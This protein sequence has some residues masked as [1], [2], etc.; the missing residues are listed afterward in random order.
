MR[1][2]RTRAFDDARAQANSVTPGTRW[3]ELRD[4]PNDPLLVAVRARTLAAAFRP[5]IGD[6]ID[7]LSDRCRGRRVLDI[8]A[9]A[10]DPRRMEAPDWL[11]GRLAD[12]AASCVAV[13]IVPE[14]VEVMRARGYTALVHDLGQ[15]PGPVAE[16]GPFEVIVAGEIIEHLE[17]QGLLFRAAQALLSDDGTMLITTPNPYVPARQKAGRRGVV[18]E[19]VDH[20]SYAFP[21][22]VAELAE[23]HGLR[24]AEAFTVTGARSARPGLRQLAKAGRR[25][26]RGQQWKSI[27][28]DTRHDLRQVSIGSPSPRRKVDASWFVGE[29][30]IYVIARPP[31]PKV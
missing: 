26:V 4:D 30:F 28:F 27:G 25:I 17:D 8:G 12:V 18:W 10:H 23:R 15:G 13:D 29:T 20:I 19:N 2:S 16:L 7:Y 14:G 24:L 11:H 21:S 3:S 1:H 6:R 22:G 5:P 9:V 31:V